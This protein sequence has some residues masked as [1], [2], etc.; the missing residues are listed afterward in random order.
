MFVDESVMVSC[1]VMERRVAALKTKELF[2][3]ISC[4]DG[5]ERLVVKNTG[6]GEH[7]NGCWDVMVT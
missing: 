7:S 4:S 1:H 2:M 3:P 5:Y 6:V